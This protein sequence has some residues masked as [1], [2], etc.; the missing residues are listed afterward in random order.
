MIRNVIEEVAALLAMLTFMAIVC[1]QSVR[2]A[3]ICDQHKVL[4]DRAMNA[5]STKNFQEARGNC[6]PLAAS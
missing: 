1:C 2:A 6:S 4:N 3:E 5:L